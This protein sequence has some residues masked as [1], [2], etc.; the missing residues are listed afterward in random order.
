MQPPVPPRGPARQ[1]DSCCSCGG[2]DQQPWLTKAWGIIVN[3]VGLSVLTWV[4]SGLYAWWKVHRHHLAGT[5]VL[6]VGSICFVVLVL[7]L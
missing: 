7:W 2:F 1:A 4:I 3:L 6:A 5:I